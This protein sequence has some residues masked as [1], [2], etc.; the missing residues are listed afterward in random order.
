MLEQF[1]RAFA[2][3][4]ASPELVKS[5]RKK[6]GMLRERYDLS[7]REWRQLVSI[8]DQPG[9]ECNCILYR[10]N[11]L[12]PVVESVPELCTA[13]GTRLRSLL[14]EFWA[15]NPQRDDNYLIEVHDFCGF[16]LEK[17]NSGSISGETVLPVL[18]LEMAAVA[19][20]LKEIYPQDQMR[21]PE[22]PA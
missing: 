2:D 18:T 22:P 4:T 9:M 1:Q 17:I 20:R 6:P 11:R 5:V 15:R 21:A 8:V 10:A 14:S 3:L 13:L 12:A 16:V 7:E 19:E